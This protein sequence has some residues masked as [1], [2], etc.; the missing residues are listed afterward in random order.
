MQKEVERK[1]VKVIGKSVTKFEVKKNL[2]KA[3]R[4]LNDDKFH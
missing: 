4:I 3:H 2:T 1:N